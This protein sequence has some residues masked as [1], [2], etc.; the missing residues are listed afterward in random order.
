MV[1]DNQITI[2]GVTV[3]F[4]AGETLLDVT[5]R[6]GRNVPTLCHDERLAPVG[7]C[8]TCL[9]EVEGA[10]RLVPACRSAAREGMQVSTTSERVE[11]HQRLLLALYLT[12]HPKD[13][14]DCENGAPCELHAMAKAFD[15]PTDWAPIPLARAGRPEDV[16]PY[17]EFREDRCIACARCTRYCDEVEGVN[18]IALTG[19]G[20]AT[21]ISTVDQLGLFDTTCELCGGCVDVCPT[22][23]MAE[24]MPL[25]AKAPPE[26]QLHKVRT[27][28]NYCGVGCQMDLNV[29][30]E[31]NL[32]GGEVVKVTSPPPGTLPS[33]GNLCVKGRFAYDF[34]NHPDRL[35]TPLIRREDG[36]LHEASWE[37]AIAFAAKGLLAVQEKHGKDALAFIS[38]SRCTAEENYLVQKMARVAFGTNNVHQCSAT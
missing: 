16:N 38:S 23:A 20:S 14:S 26:R 1:S 13:V 34:I 8:R 30:P 17:I 2:D 36:E 22:G 4:K 33:D 11:K 28:C 25:T 5:K 24:K 18:A 27:T 19:R 37:E 6:Q 9:V 3:S 32:S 12:D 31:A 15:A 10:R 29:D 21:T 7:A 35:K